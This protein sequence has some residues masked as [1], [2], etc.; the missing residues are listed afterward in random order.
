MTGT[1]GGFGSQRERPVFAVRGLRRLRPYASPASAGAKT[2]FAISAGRQ[3]A[4]T[5]ARGYDMPR[6]RGRAAPTRVVP[7]NTASRYSGR[8]YFARKKSF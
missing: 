6:Q 7:R 2:Y 4:V 5:R 1:H 3:P 8:F